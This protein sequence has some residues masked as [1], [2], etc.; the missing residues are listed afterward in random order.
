MNKIRKLAFHVLKK[1]FSSNNWNTIGLNTCN[2]C[3]NANEQWF[4]NHD[5]EPLMSSCDYCLA[6]KPLCGGGNSL[7]SSTDKFYD[8]SDDFY[9]KKSIRLMRRGIIYLIL[10]GKLPARFV[11]RVERFTKDLLNTYNEIDF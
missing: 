10:F 9:P 3:D 4:G 11:K 2:L 5:S 1:W 8:A 6:P 7:F